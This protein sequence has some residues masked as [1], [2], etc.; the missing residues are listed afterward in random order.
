MARLTNQLAAWGNLAYRMAA[1]VLVRMPARAVG[2]LR[3]R[4]RYLDAV[5]PEGYLPLLPE[6]RAAF[7]A[8]MRCVH[9]GLCALA[10]P[11]VRSAWDEAWTFVAGPSR[12]LDRARTVA[13]STGTA[14]H[15]PAAARVCP[16]GVPIPHMAA[17]IDRLAAAGEQH[18]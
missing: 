11:D 7:P 13:A 14:P 17:T 9:C 12:A 8:T 2:A 4:E 18:V 3:D 1:H 10:A 15:D 16:M 6:E 5:R